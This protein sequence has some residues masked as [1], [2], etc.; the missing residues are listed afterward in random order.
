MNTAVA[1]PD[2][3]PTSTPPLIGISSSDLPVFPTPITLYAFE[4][5]TTVVVAFEL[6]LNM[7]WGFADLVNAPLA[8][9]PDLDADLDDDDVGDGVVGGGVV[10][11]SVVVGGGSGM[12]VQNT[13]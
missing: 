5:P 2:L 13:S 7:T 6:L 10:G 1:L 8:T 4:L 9:F 11:D 12:A 3:L